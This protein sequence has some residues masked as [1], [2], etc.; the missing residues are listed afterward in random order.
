[1]ENPNA[2]KEFGTMAKFFHWTIF[3]IILFEF[4]IAI[5]MYGVATKEYHPKDLFTIHKSMGVLFFF[6]AVAR[7]TWRKLTPLPAWPESMTEFE[8]KAFHFTEIGLYTVM[9]V[10]PLSGYIFSLAGGHGFKFFGLFQIPDLIGK[11]DLL[12]S[13]GKYIHRITAFLIVGF[14]AAHVALILR[15]HF[16]S[17]D[18]FIERMSFLKS[19]K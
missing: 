16:D 9:I 5:I 1:M 6:L 10:M 8:K 13:I 15:R 12:S 2:P 14:V 18:K 7:L 19:D 3:L 11:S 4:V 17:K